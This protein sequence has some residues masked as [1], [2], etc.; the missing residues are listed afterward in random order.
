MGCLF[1]RSIIR[2]TIACTATYP[3]RRITTYAAASTPQPANAA[4]NPGSPCL[5]FVG[6]A[7]AAGA[8]VRV[9]SVALGA[10]VMRPSGGVGVTSTD[11]F[12]A[13]ADA[14]AC[15][16]VVELSYAP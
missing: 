10:G 6:V 5:G 15:V 14:A 7:P 8:V 3:L 9:C 12:D 4:V 2:T 11:A 13:N 1:L 16:A